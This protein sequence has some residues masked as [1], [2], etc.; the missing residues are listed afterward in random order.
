MNWDAIVVLGGGLDTTAQPQPWVKARLERAIE[1]ADR[2]QYIIVLSRGTPHKPPPLDKHGFPVDEATASARFLIQLGGQNPQKI[3]KDMWS[4]DTLGNAYFT[5]FMLCEPLRLRR[6]LII[7]N[8]FHLERTKYA[9]ESVFSLPGGSEC[10]NFELE[11][12][13]VE[14]RNISDRQL[15]V[16]M[17][18]E[19]E[20]LEQ[21]KLLFYEVDSIGKLAE[22][23]FIKHGAYSAQDSSSVETH[24][25]P[26]LTSTY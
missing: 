15:R 6:L 11:F 26:T 8:Q 16:R 1:V 9:F 13:G 22:Y 5:R 7:T 12:E 17:E 2:A 3:V 20:A 23:M 24:M 19:R 25:N 21:L 14:N 18:K 4:L 10:F